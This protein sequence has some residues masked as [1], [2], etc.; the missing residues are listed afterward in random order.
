MSRVEMML[1]EEVCSCGA[2]I[3]EGD[4][5]CS[6]CADN[7]EQEHERRRDGE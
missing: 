2:I 6:D 3:N 1:N 5:M 7:Y 4:V